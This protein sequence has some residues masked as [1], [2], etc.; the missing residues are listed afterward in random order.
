MLIAVLAASVIG[1]ILAA[2]KMNLPACFLAIAAIV[3]LFVTRSD[4]ETRMQKENAGLILATY[5]EGFYASM[6]ALGLA[7]L[8]TAL[9][10]LAPKSGNA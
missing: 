8:L 5:R 4:V 6:A 1:A 3:L 7:T 2:A 9:V 10:G